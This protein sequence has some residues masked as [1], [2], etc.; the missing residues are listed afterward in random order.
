MLTKLKCFQEFIGL[1]TTLI[2]FAMC[3]ILENI[4][5][6]TVYDLGCFTKALLVYAVCKVW[7]YIYVF[8]LIQWWRDQSKVPMRKIT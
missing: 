8:L 1:I 5:H 4:F 7:R 2:G 6:S 3:D